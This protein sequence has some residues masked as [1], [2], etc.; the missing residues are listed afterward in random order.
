LS[1]I[2]KSALFHLLFGILFTFHLQYTTL[3]NNP[4]GLLTNV[5]HITHYKTATEEI[6]HQLHS[7]L[8]LIFDMHLLRGIFSIA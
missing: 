4:L 7:V 6:H 8:M 5:E 1:C 3:D 2:A